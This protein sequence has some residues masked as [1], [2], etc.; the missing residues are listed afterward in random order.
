MMRGAMNRKIPKEIIDLFEKYIAN[1]V[2]HLDKKDAVHMLQTEFG[3]DED[4]AT[5]MFETFD[6][7]KN[8]QMSIWEFQQFYVCMGTHAHEV[9]EKFK[10]IDADG[11]GK[12]DRNEAVEGLLKLKTA[13]GRPLDPKE[14]DF[15]IETTSD[16][17]GQI[18]LGSF[19]NLLYRLRLYNAPPPPKDVKI[20]N[21]KAS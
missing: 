17:D 2:R 6:K 14:V 16:D 21:P 15:F 10:E 19:T 12:I 11:S 8:G 13:T 3:L 1:N 9:V 5:T 20:K 4:Q 7:D 18:N